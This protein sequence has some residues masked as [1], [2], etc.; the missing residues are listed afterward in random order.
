MIMKFRMRVDDVFKVGN[1]TIFAG[2]VVVVDSEV[3]SGKCFLQIDGIN[4]AEIEIKG[5]VQSRSHYRDLW[6]DQVI[7]I[8][9]KDLIGHDVWLIAE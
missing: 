6:T 4:L 5:E 1:K 7:N 9:S 8:C 3:I 2:D